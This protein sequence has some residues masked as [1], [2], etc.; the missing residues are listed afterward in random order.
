MQVAIIAIQAN[1][2]TDGNFDTPVY[3]IFALFAADLTCC[4]CCIHERLA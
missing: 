2:Y 1:W 4:I 3:F